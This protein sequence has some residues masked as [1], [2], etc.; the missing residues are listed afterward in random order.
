M[1]EGSCSVA[2]RA[3]SCPASALKAARLGGSPGKE[4]RPGEPE[5]LDLR[6]RGGLRQVRFELLAQPLL[7][8]AA[9]QAQERIEQ[10]AQEQ[11]E[12]E[13]AAVEPHVLEHHLDRAVEEPRC[14]F[15]EPLELEPAGHLQT[16]HPSETETERLKTPTRLDP[17]LQLERPEAGRRT[18]ENDSKPAGTSSAPSSLK[19]GGVAKPSSSC[20]TRSTFP[21]PLIP[22]AAS[23]SRSAISSV[24]G[25]QTSVKR[26]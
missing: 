4:R 3:A 20:S 2:R 1:P 6:H 9:Q 25:V 14:G 17:R 26:S 12:Q 7:D 24:R 21:R 5:R 8:F 18:C 10:V 23:C 11:P 15:G 22:A 13:I 16:F 19:A